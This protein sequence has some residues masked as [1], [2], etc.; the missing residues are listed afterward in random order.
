M[1]PTPRRQRQAAVGIAL[2]VLAPVLAGCHRRPRL[3]QADCAGI[4]QYARAQIDAITARYRTSDLT[5]PGDL[6]ALRALVS[7]DMED[8]N[9]QW[10]A[11]TDRVP[12]DCYVDA[13]HGLWLNL[14]ALAIAID[15]AG[16]TS[17]DPA[18]GR[19]AVTREVAR[20]QSEPLGAFQRCRTLLGARCR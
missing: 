9:T 18:G 11:E 15:A 19:A 17:K 16:P 6:R 12:F 3:E 7:R 1:A 4:E 20:L 10:L 2:V 8:A 14:D 5:R 13:I